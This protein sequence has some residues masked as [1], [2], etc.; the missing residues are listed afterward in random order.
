MILIVAL[1]T[2]A[3]CSGAPTAPGR[4][5]RSWPLRYADQF[6][7]T[8]RCAADPLAP[9]CSAFPV[10]LSVTWT[11]RSHADF[12]HEADV[13]N[14]ILALRRDTLGCGTFATTGCNRALIDYSYDTQS[15]L[16]RRERSSSHS[17]GGGGTLDVATYTAWD[18][19]GRPTR[20][21]LETSDLSQPLTITYDDARRIAQTSNGEFVEQDVHGNVIR[22]AQLGDTSASFEDVFTIEAVQQVCDD[23]S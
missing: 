22:E 13:P 18:A 11:Y 20:G 7:R 12:V 5:C 9:S 3:G 19:R 16:V 4:P 1:L 15:R 17:L 23:G 10:N 2:L 6:G 14:R 8:F 21:E